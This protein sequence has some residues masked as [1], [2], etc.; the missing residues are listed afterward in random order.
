MYRQSR[1]R[2]AAALAVAVA[3]AF[4]GAGLA[5][6]EPST[7]ACPHSESTPVFVMAEVEV[8]APRLP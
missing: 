5:N 7:R 4:S 6:R 2:G 1:L 3:A 8:V